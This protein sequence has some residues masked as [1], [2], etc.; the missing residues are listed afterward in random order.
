[1]FSHSKIATM[2]RAIIFTS[3]LA[4]VRGQQV[5]TLN[6]EVH[7]PLDWESCTAGK[8]CAT[9]KGLLTLDASWRD[10]FE[11]NTTNYCFYSSTQGSLWNTT[12]CP[13]DLTCAKNCGL[14]GVDYVVEAGFLV[15][16]NSLLK[17]VIPKRS[18]F[19]PSLII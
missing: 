16:D 6:A 17:Q 7:P 2:L 1:M 19:E 11:V 3:L 4:G 12:V 15:E 14:N 18:L 8:G 9:Q 10:V 13:D 5:S